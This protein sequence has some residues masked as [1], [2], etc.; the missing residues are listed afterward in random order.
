MS[1]PELKPCPFCGGEARYQIDHTTEERNSV[2][3]GKC[4]FGMFDPDDTGSVVTAWNTR[5]DLA[6]AAPKV[7][8]LEWKWQ[9]DPRDMSEA[10]TTIGSWTI[11]EIDGSGYCH[12][13]NDTS[14]KW[15]KG[16]LDGAKAAAQAD[17]EARILAALEGGDG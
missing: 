10:R 17:Y 4:D 11:W 6:P 5:A 3:C 13:P 12:G 15:C 14:G 7:K 2:W 16:G 9:R 8:A 1:A